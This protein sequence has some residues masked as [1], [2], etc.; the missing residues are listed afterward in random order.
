MKRNYFVFIVAS[1]LVVILT[2]CE[3]RI[4]LDLTQW[5]S[6]SFLTNV[7]V[8]TLQ[9]DNHKLQEY[10]ESQTLTPASRRVVVS[11]GNAKIDTTTLTATVT[12]PS[13]V[14]LS[15]TGLI[16]YHNANRIEPLNN[17]PKAGI[18]SDLSGLE[19]HYRVTS[20]DGTGK[21]WTIKIV[22]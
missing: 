21:D 12:V 9:E 1:F 6:H 22:H 18:I 5:G 14:S 17:S 3:P 7:Q 16:L 4:D 20:S 15:R 2:S 13:A 11:V 8:F 10:Y 19:Y